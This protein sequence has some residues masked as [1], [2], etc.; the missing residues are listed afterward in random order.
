[1]AVVSHSE[2]RHDTKTLL[3]GS[4]HHRFKYPDSTK[5]GSHQT[6]HKRHIAREIYH[7]LTN[8]PPTPNRAHLRCLRQNTPTT[9]A[10]AATALQTYPTRLSQLERGIYHNHHLATRYHQWLTTH[11]NSI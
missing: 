4:A 9:L 5:V 11:Q 2:R 8:P 3:S 6:V 7:L 10:H 1:M